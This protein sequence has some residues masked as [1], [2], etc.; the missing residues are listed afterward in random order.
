[1]STVNRDEF[2]HVL[3]SVKY[4]LYAKQSEQIV[5]TKSFVFQN[6]WVKTFNGTEIFCKCPSGL[7]QEFTCAVT[8]KPLMELLHKLPE[9]E[10][11]ITA[12][13]GYLIVQ[14]KGRKSRVHADAEITLPMEA[15]EKPTQWTKLHEDFGDAIGMVHSC[16]GKD[17]SQW[18]RLL[19][20]SPDH[21][22]ACDNYQVIRWPLPTGFTSDV[23]VR[24]GSIKHLSRLGM[25]HFCNGVS[26]VHFR[27]ADKLTYSICKYV[28]EYKDLTG[29]LNVNGTTTTFPKGL[30]KGIDIAEVFTGSDPDEKHIV[31]VSLA[32]GRVTLYGR[33]Q[34][35]DH[36]EGPKKASYTGPKMEF[37]ISTNVLADLIN[38]HNECVV[39]P[40]QVSVR[41]GRI[42]YCAWLFQDDNKEG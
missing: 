4:G 40:E 36:T 10:L 39:S 6:G 12:D 14:G 15:V 25:T 22:E 9:E 33:G 26:W 34:F 8:A 18:S 37:Q 35:G 20:I 28:D 7:E 38:R 42:Q 41:D 24:P 11:G 21:V 31:K 3:E 16:C 19:H 2:L 23:L 32:P 27:N 1:M 5:Q 30:L 29:L 17:E 13:K